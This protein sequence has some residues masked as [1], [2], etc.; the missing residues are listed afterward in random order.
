M[1]PGRRGFFDDLKPGDLPVLSDPL[2]TGDREGGCCYAFIPAVRDKTP[3]L[4]VG[5]GFLN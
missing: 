3:G 5:R 1:F 2:P 4:F